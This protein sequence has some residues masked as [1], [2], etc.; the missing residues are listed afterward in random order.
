VADGRFDC[1]GCGAEMSFGASEC[2]D[3]GVQ[4]RYES[5][6]P[7]ADVEQDDEKDAPRGPPVPFQYPLSDEEPS[8]A[9]VP[10]KPLV[11][12]L[13]SAL[14]CSAFVSFF[15][16][17]YL[18]L[19]G[20]NVL[21]LTTS[22]VTHEEIWL[23]FDMLLNAV[24]LGV[25]LLTGVLFLFWIHAA[26]RSA[27]SLGAEG[28]RYTPRAAVIWWFV[29]L[30]SAVL[31][32]RAMADLWKVSHAAKIERWKKGD[33]S[34]VMPWWWALWLGTLVMERVADA[35]ENASSPSSTA[36]IVGLLVRMSA[37]VLAAW[38]VFAIQRGLT[39]KA[40]PE[41]R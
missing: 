18:V 10:S 25:A 20:Q 1:E 39:E 23:V 14:C 8:R 12:A 26:T 33:T 34:A 24:T 6:R 4:Y 36:P 40:R 19:L 29:P 31:P 30:A 28:L 37:A 16:L 22:L 32:Y 35:N 2:A 7:V 11:Y 5:G 17:T 41:L 27:R 3:C 15:N 13:L 9:F 21:D 38:V